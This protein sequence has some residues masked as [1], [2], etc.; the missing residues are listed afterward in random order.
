MFSEHKERSLKAAYRLAD[1]RQ[2][3]S[4]KLSLH[5]PVT[6]AHS[7]QVL[8]LWGTVLDKNQA[9]DYA[10]ILLTETSVMVNP[11]LTIS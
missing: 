5:P 6:V 10:T 9:V 8:R 11:Q 4:S 7:T 3:I 1:A 2:K